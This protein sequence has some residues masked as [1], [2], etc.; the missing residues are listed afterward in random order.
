MES[1]LCTS[2]VVDSISGERLEPS[3]SAIITINV[4][5]ELNNIIVARGRNVQSQYNLR[6]LS[7]LYTDEIYPDR[8]A[9]RFREQKKNLIVLCQDKTHI[10]NILFYVYEF[11]A[12]NNMTHVINDEYRLN[13]GSFS[14]LERFDFEAIKY[15]VTNL[16]LENVVVCTLKGLTTMSHIQCIS[17]SGSTLGRTRLEKETFWNWMTFPNIEDSLTVLL[18]DSINLTMVPFEMQN[19]YKLKSL[20][21][22]D[23]NLK[24]LPHFFDGMPE[25]T[26]LFINNNSLTYLPVM[27]QNTT[28]KDINIADNMLRLPNSESLRIQRP[29]PE[30]ERKTP[31]TLC[32][33]ALFSMVKNKVKFKRQDINRTLWDY[34]NN[35]SSCRECDRMMVVTQ[36]NAFYELGFVR[37]YNYQCAANIILWQYSECLHHCIE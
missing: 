34:F 3:H 30:E 5:P 17:L 19:L 24:C 1:S 22:A 27:L 16:I 9:M 6:E 7:G 21:M 11:I 12:L 32:N 29:K 35:I 37:A 14:C 28:F 26:S 36:Q 33:L 25:L 10:R 13:M 18:L 31:E 4:S 20:S 8:L 15:N 2:I 23:N